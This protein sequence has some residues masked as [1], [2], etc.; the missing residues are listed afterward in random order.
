MAGDG[1]RL[2]DRAAVVAG[3]RDLDV[4]DET[5]DDDEEKEEVFSNNLQ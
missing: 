1:E 4:V 5:E 2:F 3:E